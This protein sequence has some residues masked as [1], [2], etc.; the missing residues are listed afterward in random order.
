MG[1]FQ[2]QSVC[3]HGATGTVYRAIQ[4]GMD[5]EVAVKLVGQGV[6]VA[7]APRSLATAETVAVP[8][9]DLALFRT[10]G[11]RW[12][13]DL[14]PSTLGILREVIAGGGRPTD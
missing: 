6:G 7:I 1:Q 9:A 12:R 10:I 2:I 5:R 13:A 11:L 4:V 3:G 14:A 8:I